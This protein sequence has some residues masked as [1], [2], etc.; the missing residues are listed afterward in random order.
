MAPLSIFLFLTL[1]RSVNQKLPLLSNTMS[2]GPL[3][4]VLLQLSYKVENSPV[5]ILTFC[6]FP[7]EYDLLSKIGLMNLSF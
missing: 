3:R 2:F 5:T 1:P 6:I 4:G 7:P